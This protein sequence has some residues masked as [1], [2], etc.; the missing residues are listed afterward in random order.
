MAWNTRKP[1]IDFT[2]Y[3]TERATDF[4][5]RDWVLQA[6]NNW[7]AN[8][9]GPRYFLLTGE[10]GSGKT[11][12]AS[13]LS[14]FSQGSVPPPAGTKRLTPHFISAVHFCSA[15]D[16]CWINPYTFTESLT[17]QLAAHYPAYAQA[18]AEKS[19]E[20]QIHIEVQQHIGHGQ[21][22]G[23]VTHRIDVSGGAVEDVFNRVVREPLEAL[24]Q[25][26]FDQ[27]IVILIDALDEALSYS[28]STS[29]VPLLA[30]INEL[31]L[32]VRFIL[33]SRPDSRVEHAFL[34]VETLALSATPFH[35]SNQEDI[36]HYVQDRLKNN[37]LLME[38]VTQLDSGRVVEQMIETIVSKAE[39]NFLY[40]RFLLNAIANGE[41]SL[42]ELE[43]LPQR[44]DGLYFESLQRVVKLGKGD[45]LREY[46]PIMG[47]LAVAQESPTLAQLQSFTGQS[48]S[49]VLKYLDELWQFIEEVQ[50]SNK[51]ET[52]YR[53]YHQSVIDFLHSQ[54]LLS[55][56]RQ[57]RN[58]FYLPAEEWY[59]ALAD[60]CDG[61]NLAAIWE[62]TELDPAEQ[63]RRQYAR[64]YYVTHLY[65]AYEW[66]RLFA[67]L[68]EGAYGQAKVQQY[69]PSTLS[70]AQDLDLGRQA[71]SYPGK[72]GLT[73]LLQL[74]K[75]TL[76]RCSLNSTADQYMPEAFEALLLL[77]REKEARDI[78]EL[79]T[80]PDN[81]ARVLL[82]IANYLETQP[83]REQEHLELLNRI[84]DVLRSTEESEEKA[85]VSQGLCITFLR[86][87]Q[88]AQ[89]GAVADMVEDGKKKTWMLQRLAVAL[90]EAREWERAETIAHTID[91]QS[92]R[93]EALYVIGALLAEAHDLER[94]EAMW[95]KAEAL[96]YQIQDSEERAWALEGF[97]GILTQVQQWE[98]ALAM[99]RSI[100]VKRR[101]VWALQNL[102]E[103]LARAGEWEQAA[104]LTH[105]IEFIKE[106]AKALFV[107]GIALARGKYQERAEKVWSEAK[108]LVRTIEDGRA[109]VWALLELGTILAQEGYQEQAEAMWSEAEAVVRTIEENRSR[110]SALLEIGKTYVQVQQLERAA[111]V[112]AEAEVLISTTGTSN[113]WGIIL[114]NFITLLVQAQRWEQAEA[115]ARTIEDS[116]EKAWALQELCEAFAQAGQWKRA[117]AVASIIED[118]RQKARALLVLCAELARAQQWKQADAVW[119]KVPAVNYFIREERE[120]KV[121]VLQEL[122][123]ALAKAQQSTQADAVLTEAEALID[124]IEEDTS[125][126]SALYEIS[127]TLARAGYWEW[128]EAIARSIKQDTF[129]GWALQ[130]HCMMLAQMHQWEQAIAFAR[131]IEE[132]S[133]KVNAL[134]ELGIVLAHALRWEPAETVLDEADEA[135]DKVGASNTARARAL[136]WFG[137]ALL[138]IG[139][140]VCAEAA[141]AEAEEM[142]R[143][144]E[145][146]Q[147]KAG[148]LQMISV[149]LAQA[150]LWERAMVVAGEI[151]ER[152]V[153]ANAL[154]Q[155]GVALAQAHHWEE[156]EAVVQMVED[157]KVKAWV[158]LEL[159]TALAQAGYLERAEAKWAESE[160][161]AQTI[162]DYE[163][164]AFAVQRLGIA[165]TQAG[166]L[167]RAEAKLAEAE[168]IV[169]MIKSSKA[170]DWA[171]L[172][173][174][175]ML[176]QAQQWKRA[177]A[178][179]EMIEHD[180]EKARALIGL[181]TALSE[182]GQWNQ[183]EDVLVEVERLVHTIQ[184]HQSKIGML[185]NMVSI[186]EMAGKPE[187]M[188]HLIQRSLLQA[189]TKIYAIRL[190]SLITRLIP[191]KPEIGITFCEA[192]TWVDS[193]SKR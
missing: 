131:L 123:L 76:L 74:W 85:S 27:Q 187:E 154:Q 165:L 33:T 28:G 88:W 100:E 179:A 149:T 35:E 40:V 118:V 116:S 180:D 56:R 183:A 11:A 133:V 71:A 84:Y 26:E 24:Y 49:C 20:G 41:R 139:E 22:T 106:R 117:E 178:V 75:Y 60:W 82:Q 92:A 121:S 147:A 127:A 99:A 104:A 126:A 89:A 192:F 136:Y 58:L 3:I 30:H 6:V 185:H 21:G 173:L 16:S 8:P 151:E 13:R 172:G 177:K 107:L 51:G 182:S 10:P 152:N 112:L 189:S 18:L 175:L 161:V 191:R 190:L 50:S 164:R 120:A 7:L 109:K 128:A 67:V 53:L 90:A 25:S 168:A 68:D 4:T 174:C 125:R 96:V 57:L 23:I 93:A 145:E 81:K 64:A 108:S 124:T 129:R 86:K 70:Y 160:M 170:K 146:G 62:D 110:G 111:A 166:Y 37:T 17:K 59:K 193:F 2:S 138:Q 14:Q 61:S 150:Q 158:L 29:I 171:L 162:N 184:D 153:R 148:V 44:L 48:K 101:R 32:G 52:G 38:K 98:R 72:D 80:K 102:C 55:M 65:A 103:G 137:Y 46:A 156:A 135:A 159:G 130:G 83:G 113:P 140:Q 15:R 94:A 45:W 142:V 141:L 47:M 105:E 188:L 43:G 9:A 66:Q 157:S 119:N 134:Q 169:F 31:P 63:G 12:I 1:V 19:G 95:F 144:I 143:T 39:G 186:F 176:V 36:R 97:C 34:D 54:S 73:H 78:A 69:D 132:S 79:L 91:E 163:G 5:G 42:T 114:P 77:K 122:G 155:L 115:I 167:E 87:R 181:A